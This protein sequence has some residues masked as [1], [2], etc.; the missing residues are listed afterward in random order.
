M[1]LARLCFISSIPVL[2]V[3]GNPE[4]ANITMGFATNAS[5]QGKE[6]GTSL[7]KSRHET[8]LCCGASERFF[9]QITQ[10]VSFQEFLSTKRFCLCKLI[11]NDL[12]DTE[13]CFT[14]APSRFMS[15][16]S[17]AAFVN[18]TGTQKTPYFTRPCTC[19]PAAPSSGPTPPREIKALGAR[20]TMQQARAER[21]KAQSD[22]FAATANVQPGF[23]ALS[24]LTDGGTGARWFKAAGIF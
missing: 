17:S 19:I 8:I 14:E 22:Q 24:E 6:V 15:W 1:T 18:D 23:V 20:E 11:E 4:A 13:G 21:T 7:A 9:R 5:M 2:L 16:S 3:V 12:A 10:A